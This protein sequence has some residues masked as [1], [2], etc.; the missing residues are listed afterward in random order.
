MML[1]H[2]AEWK[3]CSDALKALSLVHQRVPALRV[4]MFGV[5]A[6]PANLPTWVEYHRTPT[7]E[8]LRRL[9][10][11][12]AIF[13]APSWTEGWGLTAC[14]AL[15]CGSAL[16]ATDIGGHREFAFDGLT[17]L[18]CAAKDPSQ[19]A[20]RTLRLIHNAALRMRLAQ[21]GNEYVRQFTWE[22]ATTKFEAVLL[23]ENHHEP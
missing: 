22:R 7:R 1:Y 5:P 11:E 20:D 17:A 12:A 23:G 2:S 9:Y 19:L 8:L 6:M 18:M 3:G 14:E 15:L 4:T 13:I 16:V 10:N 21:Q